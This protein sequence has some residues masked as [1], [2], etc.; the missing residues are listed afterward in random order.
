MKVKIFT[1]GGYGGIGT[2]EDDINDWLANGAGLVTIHH[3][4]TAMTQVAQAGDAER[5]QF[6]TVTVW[7][8]EES[9]E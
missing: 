8:E 2:M 4:N 6:M 5:R 1:G 3:T 7:Y 9:Y